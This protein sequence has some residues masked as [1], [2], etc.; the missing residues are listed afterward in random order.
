MRDGT[1]AQYA[2][3]CCAVSKIIKK[4]CFP[5]IKTGGPA[6]TCL[7]KSPLFPLVDACKKTG[8]PLDFYSRRSHPSEV[9]GMAPHPA[10][11]RTMPDSRGFGAQR[12]A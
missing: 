9:A 4:R 11:A 2:G 7:G 5:R 3:F 12:S 6:N 10:R 1:C 8:A